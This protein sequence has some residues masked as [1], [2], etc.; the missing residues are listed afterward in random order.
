MSVANGLHRLFRSPIL[1][2]GSLTLAF[3]MFVFDGLWKWSVP[4][5]T[6]ST[7]RLSSRAS[8]SLSMQQL[9]ERLIEGD[10]QPIRDRIASLQRE[11]PADKL[12]WNYGNVFHQIMILIGLQALVEDDDLAAAKDFLIMASQTR[13]S[14]QLNTFGPNMLLAKALLERGEFETVE[15]YLEHCKAFWDL[16]SPSLDNWINDVRNHKIPDFGANIEY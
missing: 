11:L 1:R 4:A 14:P 16:G 12:D 7:T 6:T 2:F 13:G 3:G 5:K 15:L 9:Y 10:S 8:A